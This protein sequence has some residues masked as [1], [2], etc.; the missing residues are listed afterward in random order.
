MDS[1]RVPRIA[2]L[3]L[4]LEANAFAPPTVLED[5]RRQCLERGA[6]ISALARGGT[7]HL[8]MEIPGFYARMD[9]TGPWEAVP[10]LI[11]AA[12][13]GGPVA[14]VVFTG[15]MDEMQRGL[16]AALPLD[17]VYIASHG[18]SSATGDEDSDGTIAA[19][20]RRQVGPAVPVVCS[21]DLHCNVSEALVRA[22]DALVVYRTNPHVDMAARAAESADLLRAMLGGMRP[23]R[24]FIRLP[25]TPPSVTLLTAEGPYADLIHDAEVLMR[26]NPAV[27]N[28]SVAGGFVFSDLP[29]CGMTVTITARDAATAEAAAHRLAHRAWAERERYRR[30]LTPLAEAVAHA[31]AAGRG[32]APPVLL[33]DVADNP[34]G[35]G[36]GS[37][38]YLLR[39]LHKAGAQGV[40]LGV[41]I[42]PALA[43]EAQALGEGA[44]FEAVFNRVE[45]EF[46]ERFAAPARVLVLRDGRGV[47]RRGTM[48]GRR[49]D[50]GPSAL[51]ELAGSGL[52]V[53]VGS[54]RRQLHEPAMLELHD[55]DIGAARCVVVKS[56]GH[57]RAGFDEYF[58]GDRIIEVDAPGLTSPV[59]G[60]FAWK[61]L[62]RPVFPLDEDAVWAR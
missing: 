60:N 52:R 1:T 32:E 31:T 38:A 30:P 39:A 25:L 50:L 57:F 4:H 42:D 10:L 35:G 48:A 18:A 51:L 5:F 3:G 41:F 13:P 55:I 58:A 45:S 61:R 21:H 24:A 29:K 53:V 49:F 59:L 46:S 12:P 2:I 44:A 26:D 62:P 23:H 17:G 22:V 15:F 40:V 28:A 37:T 6:A 7:S 54:L 47:G 33:A 9:A 27:L 11:A 56:R 20:V 19:M 34:G 16:A 8:P 36:R 14:Q 43:A